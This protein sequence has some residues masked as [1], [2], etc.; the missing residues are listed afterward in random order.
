MKLNK[1]GEKVYSTFWDPH[2]VG[3]H[4]TGL[5]WGVLT[6]LFTGDPSFT[7]RASGVL[8]NSAL[9]IELSHHLQSHSVTSHLISK[10][11]LDSKWL[12][13]EISLEIQFNVLCNNFLQGLQLEKKK[14]E[15]R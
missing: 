3:F 15:T 13:H 9:S 14:G 12:V 5:I 2:S 1:I 6:S 7:R 8:F 11:A 4:E 10:Q